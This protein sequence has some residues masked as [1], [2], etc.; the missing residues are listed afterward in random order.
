MAKVAYRGLGFAFAYA[1]LQKIFHV[2]AETPTYITSSASKI[3]PAATLFADITPEYMGVGY[4]IGPRIAGVLVAGGILAW[5]GIIPLIASLVP[6]DVIA[7]QLVKLGYL[8]DIGKA[9]A[10]GWD[11]AAHS[12]GQLNRA[13]Y[14]AYVR[15]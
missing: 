7:S 9:G 14:F 15:R 5:L 12:F 6:A 3:F 8:A 13:I 4:I 11:P 2:I 10:Y 1:M